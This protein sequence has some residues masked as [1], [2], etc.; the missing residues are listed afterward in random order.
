[1]VLVFLV[2]GIDRRDLPRVLQVRCVTWPVA[3][4]AA[5]S[6]GFVAKE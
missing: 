3:S 4:K 5:C 6:A 2:V 1:M